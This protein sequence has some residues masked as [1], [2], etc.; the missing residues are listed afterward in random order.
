MTQDLAVKVS[1]ATDGLSKTLMIGERW[2][3][4]R[5]WPL[6]G[7]YSG[8]YG[9]ARNP[10][11]P[12]GPTPD[13]AMSCCKNIDARYPINLPPDVKCYQSHQ[14]ESDRP[15]V[16]NSA[17]REIAFND[18]TWGSFHPGGANFA[19]GDGSVQLVNEDIDANIYVA[20]GSRNGDET[21]SE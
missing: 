15:Q 7:Y 6:G 11:A 13:A 2:Y 4:T 19:R 10:V 21:V 5:A 18:L 12:K 1:T 8:T 9:S 20:L 16:P 3:Q 14:N 17:S